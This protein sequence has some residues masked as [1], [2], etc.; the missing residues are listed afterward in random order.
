MA[1]FKLSTKKSRMLEAEEHAIELNKDIFELLVKC[2]KD[3]GE[4]KSA[5]SSNNI[6]MKAAKLAELENSLL[7]TRTKIDAI[8]SDMNLI[9]NIETQ[10]RDFIGFNDD[11]YI[12]DKINRLEVIS[13]ALEELLDLANEKPAA[14][15]LKSGILEFING[16]INLIIDAVNNI[17]NDDKQLEGTYSKIQYL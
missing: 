16:K 14:N 9:V 6:F 3:L 13:Q 15:E 11:K 4:L 1:W 10:N 5:I 7:N 12:N 2:E 8:K 17:I